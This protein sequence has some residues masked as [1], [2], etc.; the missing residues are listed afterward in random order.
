M[1]QLM[2]IVGPLLLLGGAIFVVAKRC[3][4]LGLCGETAPDSGTTTDDSGVTSGGVDETASNLDEQGNWAGGSTKGCCVCEMQGDRVKCSKHGGAW[5]NPP[6]GPDGSNDQ[7]VELSL[8]ECNKTCGSSST[9]LTDREKGEVGTV[10][11]PSGQ[12]SVNGRCVSSSSLSKGG[13]SSSSGGSKQSPKPAPKKSSVTGSGQ[14][15]K[16]KPGT[17]YADYFNANPKGYKPG[18]GTYYTYYPYPQQRPRYYRSYFVDPYYVR[19]FNLY[20]RIAN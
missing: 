5:Y 3:E 6:A 1:G 9:S 13:G 17:G 18:G 20:H 4:L 15:I 7:S 10:R 14:P 11:C 12:S 16:P 8:K 19:P 2:N